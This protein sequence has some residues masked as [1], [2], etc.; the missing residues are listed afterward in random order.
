MTEIEYLEL[1]DLLEKDILS[2]FDI[3]KICQYLKIKLDG[4]Y[5]SNQFQ[6]KWL[7]YNFSIVLNFDTTDG[8]GT[9]WVG[10]YSN[11]KNIYYMDSYGEVPPAKIYN[12]IIR[13]DL[14]LYF[15]NK[16]YQH[17]NSQSCGWFVIY[18]LYLMN[19]MKNKMKAMIKF[20]KSFNYT[21]YNAN[22]KKIKTIMLKLIKKSKPNI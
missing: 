8:G 5:M 2:N 14:E 22:D 15:N 7:E 19:S 1:L 18:F 21:D 4:V 16:Q 17:L 10:M 12:M 13:K 20:L 11:N 3:V 9:H 6:S